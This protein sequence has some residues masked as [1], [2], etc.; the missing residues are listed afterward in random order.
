MPSICCSI[1]RPVPQN[2]NQKF[3]VD[4]GMTRWY[5]YPKADVRPANGAQTMAVA[6]NAYDT[7]CF[8]RK[9]LFHEQVCEEE[10]A[11]MVSRKLAL[12]AILGLLPWG[13]HYSGVVDQ[14][15]DEGNILPRVHLRCCI[16]DALERGEIDYQALGENRGVDAGDIFGGLLRGSGIPSSQDDQSRTSFRDSKRELGA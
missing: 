15:I 14:N 8:G 2:I 5:T 13:R 7:W 12:K 3:K 11:Q 16:A 10:V 1:C 9:D 4:T 6:A